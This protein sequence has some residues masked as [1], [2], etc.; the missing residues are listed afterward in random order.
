MIDHRRQ[1]GDEILA[2]R[3]VD[4]MAT[5]RVI[6]IASEVAGL[7]GPGVEVVDYDE[8]GRETVDGDQG[9]A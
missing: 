9:R 7:G 2:K 5:W 1:G 8:P 6:D 4:L 3:P